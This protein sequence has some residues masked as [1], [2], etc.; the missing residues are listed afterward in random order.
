MLEILQEK[1][2]EGGNLAKTCNID[3]LIV[4]VAPRKILCGFAAQSQ[5]FSPPKKKFFAPYKRGL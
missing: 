5:A 1:M 3:L 4:I 2:G